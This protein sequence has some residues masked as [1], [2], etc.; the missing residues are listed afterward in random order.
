MRCYY[1]LH[2]HTALSPCGDNDMTPGNIVG[3]AQ[4]CGLS[5]I[6]VTDHNS[7]GN[8]G[9]VIQ[10][11][12]ALG[13]PV[14]PGME[15]CT[16][17]EIHVVCLFPALPQ[18]Q[19]F[20]AA[21]AARRPA[22]ANR[23]DIFG[24]QRFMDERDTVT[25]LEPTLLLTATSLTLEE[26]LPLARAHGGTAFPAHIDRDSY[27]VP[28]ALG[29]IPPLGFAAA[30]ITAGGDVEKLKAAYP[31]IAGAVLPLDSDA[32]Y[33]HQIAEAGAW[34]ELPA[35]TPQAV[36]DALDGRLDCRWGRSN[37]TK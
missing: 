26:V 15:L 33:L 3:M 12:Q 16:A 2:I 28:A 34:L 29:D 21:V 30:E 25:G 7:C 27:S 18:A 9:A 8:C 37:D 11:G 17:E 31:A 24:E 23:P 1:D 20:E 5:I 13:L 35:C 6:A 22:I 36:I 10:A 4:L 19:A 32:H 14:I